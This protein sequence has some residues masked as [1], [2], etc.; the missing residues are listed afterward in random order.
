MRQAARADANQQ[1]IISALRNIGVMVYYIK[2][3]TD[4]LCA[5]GPLN[6][7]NL[8]LEVKMPGEKLSMAQQEFWMRWP[9]EKAVVHSV[10]EAL[11]VILGDK[12]K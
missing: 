8:L 11:E 6:S 10:Q 9:G 1:M 2:L 12:L 5:G 3:P 4:L 7:R